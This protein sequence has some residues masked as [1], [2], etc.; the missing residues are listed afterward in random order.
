MLANGVVQIVQR[1]EF[2]A[3]ADGPDHLRQINDA[4]NTV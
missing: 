1:H 4:V 2:R 3:V